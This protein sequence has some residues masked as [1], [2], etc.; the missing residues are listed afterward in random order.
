[1]KEKLAIAAVAALLGYGLYYSVH[2]AKHPADDPALSSIAKATPVVKSICVTP[3]QN[4][5]HKN[6]TMD[7]VDDEFVTQLRKVGFVSQKISDGGAKCDA[8]TNAE[9]VDITGRGRK[10]ARIDFRLTLTNEQVPRMSS[11]VEGKSGGQSGESLEKTVSEFKINPDS[12]ESAG[13]EHEAIVMALGKTAAQID[14]ANK[15]GLPP[16]SA[17]EQ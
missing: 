8:T 2:N 7:G 15:R 17:K 9:V 16:W 11:S 10:T 5:S 13:A 4:L 3:I 14:A 6:V 12:K 1:M